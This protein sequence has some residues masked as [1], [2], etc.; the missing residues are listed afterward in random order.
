MKRDELEINFLFESQD[1]CVKTKTYKYR[2]KHLKLKGDLLDETISLSSHSLTMKHRLLD[3]K[4]FQIAELNDCTDTESKSQPKVSELISIYEIQGDS[5]LHKES[6]DQSTRSNTISTNITDKLAIM[7]SKKDSISNLGCS[8]EVGKS[9]GRIKLDQRDSEKISEHLTRLLSG[10]SPQLTELG[11]P[12]NPD[13][14]KDHIYQEKGI[15]GNSI[16]FKSQ[17][18]KIISKPHDNTKSS[19]VRKSSSMLLDTLVNED[20]LDE[21]DLKALDL[22]L[23]EAVEIPFSDENAR[24]SGNSNSNCTCSNIEKESEKKFCDGFFIVGVDE[25][26]PILKQ[27]CP[28]ER[29]DSRDITIG[30]PLSCGHKNCLGNPILKPTIL[31]RFP[32][33]DTKALEIS[34][35]ISSLCFPY[36]VQICTSQKEEDFDSFPN[37]LVLN[38]NLEGVRFYTASQCLFLKYNASE[39][40]CLET[41][42]DPIYI[43]SAICLISQNPFSSQMQICLGVL[44]K[45]FLLMTTGDGRVPLMI[46]K[47]IGHCL[48][49]IP[50]PAK[51]SRLFFFLPMLGSPIELQGAYKDLP[52]MNYNTSIL[53]KFLSVESI[54]LIHHLMLL[55]QKI[56]L[57]G[58][59]DCLLPLCESL[60]ALI[61]PLQWVNIFIPVLIEDLLKYLQSF[62]SFLMGI[63]QCMLDHCEE[64][65]NEEDSIWLVYLEDNVISKALIRKGKQ[66]ISIRESR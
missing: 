11:V 37:H 9:I 18:E 26:A 31:R 53:F 14:I 45:L 1:V 20:I 34:E 52:I 36:G 8:Y 43:P 10:N 66:E 22:D 12:V 3:E 44:A 57:V 56:L 63:E 28:F 21:T 41:R 48:N 42:S 58:P 4:A 5:D 35:I 55:E 19:F 24:I 15:M 65:I 38:T 27:P 39:F 25:A 51:N 32:L 47:I 54:V 2:V 17:L 61:Y 62:M 60:I 49:E 64:Y 29:E 30:N 23:L 13:S 46:E 6:I 16:E 50:M 7:S 59:M 33:Q 40:K